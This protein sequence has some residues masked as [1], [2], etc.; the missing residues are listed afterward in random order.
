MK[1][2]IILVC[3]TLLFF[4]S[5]A[6]EIGDT[7]RID[8]G[9]VS[10]TMDGDVRVFRGIP[11]G[12][13][14]VGDLRWKPPQPVEP[15]EGVRD[16]AEFGFSCLYVPYPPGSLWTGPEWD[17]PAE[18]NEDCLHLNV[19]TAAESPD[20]KRPVMVWIHGG[21]LKSESGAVGAYGGAILARKGVVAVTIN[22]RLGP[23]GYLAHPELTRESAHGSSGNYG[24][25]DQIAALEWVQRNIAAFGGDPDRVTIFGESAGSWS[26][27]FLVA[28]PLAKGLF[29]RA[30][31]QSGAAFGP[32][33]RMYEKSSW[34]AWVMPGSPG[35]CECGRI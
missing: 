3:A 22:Y 13:P 17:D 32:M 18:Q 14:R 16:C 4:T 30:I 29:H 28:T 31:G 20:E 27:N 5:C 24:V 34:Q 1:R 21:S 2:C 8:S 23:F 33:T 9:L 26:V 19:W 25:L 11:Y 15:W 35:R 12:A 6:R 10:G 7:I